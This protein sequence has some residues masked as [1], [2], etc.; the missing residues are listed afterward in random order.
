MQFQKT[1]LNR[2]KLDTL[3]YAT[4]QFDR[5]AVM[6]ARKEMSKTGT[7]SINEYLSSLDI[8]SVEKKA[9]EQKFME[10]VYTFNRLGAG[11]Y[12]KSLD[13]QTIFNI[14]SPTFFVQ[15]WEK[16]ETFVRDKQTNNEKAYTFFKWLANEC[17]NLEAQYPEVYDRK[18]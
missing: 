3:V 5:L 11:I 6:G 18:V 14:W 4:A 15:R 10:Y 9:A 13:R 8:D 12:C 1:Q 7:K 2:F 16:F 17:K